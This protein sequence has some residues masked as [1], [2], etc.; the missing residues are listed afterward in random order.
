MSP[1]ETK[2]KIVELKR[3]PEFGRNVLPPK[4]EE[5]EGYSYKSYSD[6]EG[7]KRS[8]EGRFSPPTP[9][10]KVNTTKD[11]GAPRSSLTSGVKITPARR[12]LEAS[13]PGS[14]KKSSTSDRRNIPVKKDDLVKKKLI[15]PLPGSEEKKEIYPIPGSEGF[16]W[17][18]FHNVPET[19]EDYEETGDDEDEANNELS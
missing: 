18:Y 17:V 11:L 7:D 12:Q 13:R 15:H 8:S 4:K 5:D 3:K 2:R 10:D 16:A 6:E 9:G 19:I 14:D 1:E